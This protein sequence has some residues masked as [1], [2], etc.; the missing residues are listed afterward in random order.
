MN[1]YPKELF[2]VQRPVICQEVEDAIKSGVKFYNN[3]DTHITVGTLSI[4]LPSPS[5]WKKEN[6]EKALKKWSQ[7]NN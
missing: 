5:Y 2:Q 6:I 4:P 1:K 3:V 7:R